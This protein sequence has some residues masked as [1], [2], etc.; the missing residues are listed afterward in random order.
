MGADMLIAELSEL[1]RIPS[2]SADPSHADDVER[3]ALWVADY[4]RAAGGEAELLPYGERPL[5]VG[6]IRA[7]TRADSAPTV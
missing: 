6:E 1:L 2:L 7:S 5:V 3:A 4:V